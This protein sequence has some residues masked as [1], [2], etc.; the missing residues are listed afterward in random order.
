MSNGM[1][2]I[3]WSRIHSPSTRG[4]EYAVGWLA[5]SDRSMMLS[6]FLPRTRIAAVQV[7]NLPTIS[8]S[9]IAAARELTPTCV[10]SYPTNYLALLGYGEFDFYLVSEPH[11]R[12]RRRGDSPEKATASIRRSICFCR[13]FTC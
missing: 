11:R 10:L 3:F 13:S 5:F 2:A 9:P 1:C 7:K 4:P 6:M 8:V 12:R